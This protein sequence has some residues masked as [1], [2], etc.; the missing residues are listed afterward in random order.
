M[1]GIFPPSEASS[2]TSPECLDGYQTL[3]SSLTIVGRGIILLSLDVSHKE[4]L[5]HQLREEE[6]VALFQTWYSLTCHS[7]EELST[8]IIEY[9]DGCTDDTLTLTILDKKIQ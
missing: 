8:T 9:D 6:N 3:P 2:C 5:W 7:V 1:A 4:G